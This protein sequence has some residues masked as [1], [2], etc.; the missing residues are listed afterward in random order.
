[1]RRSRLS[2][3]LGLL[4][5]A[6]CTPEDETMTRFVSPSGRRAVVVRERCFGF[7]C[8]HRVELEGRLWNRPLGDLDVGDAERS[9]FPQATLRWSRDERRVEWATETR[10]G[11][12]RGALDLE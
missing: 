6:A 2:L 1:V 5:A 8:Y 7:G 9:V 10:H 11:T 4:L 12:K 3:L